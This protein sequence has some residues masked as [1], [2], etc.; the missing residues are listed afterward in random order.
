[1]SAVPDLKVHVLGLYGPEV[2]RRDIECPF[3][4]LSGTS[5][6]TQLMS[7]IGGK[8]DIA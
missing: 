4:A 3:L 5:Q 1:L 2:G 7:A 6:S 8:A